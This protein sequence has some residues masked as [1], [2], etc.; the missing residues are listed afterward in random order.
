LGSPLSSRAAAG[1]EPH[2]VHAV[3]Q[4]VLQAIEPDHAREHVLRLVRDAFHSIGVVLARA[5]QPEIAET[6]ILER[7][8]HVG[9]V[10][11]ILGLVEHHGDTH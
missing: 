10:D 4:R 5:H 1:R 8:N 9:D 3:E 7:A 2:D 11:E 6:E